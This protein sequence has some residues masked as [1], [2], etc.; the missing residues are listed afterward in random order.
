MKTIL[1]A[2]NAKYIHTNLAVR[3]LSEYSKNELGYQ[4]PIVEYT[5]NHR[6]PI[7]IDEI[8]RK[9]ADCIMFSCY[10][11]NIEYVKHIISML[12][13]ISPNTTIVLG[14]PE[15][16][17]ESDKFLEENP[18]A[19]IIIKGE[20]EDTMVPLIHALEKNED[21]SKVDGIVYRGEKEILETSDRPPID[22]AKLPFAYPDIEN[23]HNKI[24]YFE[25]SRGCPF[26]CSYC[27]S[28]ATGKVRLMPVELAC[29]YLDIFLKN[30]VPQVKFVDRTYNCNKKH[31]MG[32]W[33]Y[34]RD[35]DNGVTNFHFEISA[36]L[37]DQE[38]LDFFKT[39]RKEQFQLEV[40]VQSTN[41]VTIKH[42]KRTTDTDKLLNICHEIDSYGNIHQ[43]LD[44]IAGL[45]YEGIE[46]FEASFNR[47]YSM[48]PQ[49][50]QLGFLKVLKGS[51]MHDQAEEF[52]IIYNSKAPFEVLGTNWLNYDEI[53][54][55]KGVEE[56]T[57]RYYNSGRF[58]NTLELLTKNLSSPFLFFKQLGKYFVDH[59]YHLLSLSKE[60]PHT[61]LKEFYEENYGKYDDKII[62]AVLYDLCLKEKPKK[63]PNWI[64]YH[65]TSK[66]KDNIT[67]FFENEENI[68][69][70]LPQ[71]VGE[72]GKRVSRM[73]HLQVFE[74][75]V[76]DKELKNE[77]TFV[78]F[79]YDNT[80]LLGNS[81][82]CKIDSNLLDV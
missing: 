66:Y 69:K 50:L 53:L 29:K 35:H 78:L 54:E 79:N 82:P 43:H 11:W 55:L 80:D 40:G 15:V 4:I 59:K 68:E 34:L 72:H 70:Y 33:K 28:S 52:G 58:R 77:L 24:F 32:I 7:I 75:D 13:K 23:I 60:A 81:I 6:L 25:S 57:E 49:Q 9:K 42:I 64:D 44:L 12:K 16:S 71:Y 26:R 2:I 45:P 65:W 27:L 38:V 30:K 18:C 48:R 76:T 73:A 51:L 37:I 61:I 62:S 36:H 39:V 74:Y 14:G 56:M 17:Y 63:L 3:Y 41:P 10:I 67:D 31:A 19:D 46:S 47:V 21:L 8:Y 1:V 5:I 22:L 20:G